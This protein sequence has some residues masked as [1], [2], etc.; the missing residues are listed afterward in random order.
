MH[1]TLTWHY[2][3]IGVGI[4][5]H[6]RFLDAWRTVPQRINILIDSA[7]LQSNDLTHHFIFA[8]LAGEPP[9]AKGPP[10]DPPPPHPLKRCNEKTKNANGKGRENLKKKRSISLRFLPWRNPF[11]RSRHALS[12]QINI[13]TE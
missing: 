10:T 12:K 4:N 13:W 2:I 3:N 7:Y 1:A 8:V 5:T 11:I 6:L 9:A